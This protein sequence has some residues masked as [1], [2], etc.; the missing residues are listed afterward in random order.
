MPITHAEYAAPPAD[1]GRPAEGTETVVAGPPGGRERPRRAGSRD[2]QLRTALLA[3]L[4]LLAGLVVMKGG[5]EKQ[6]PARSWDLVAA[7]VG[8]A[9][10]S[11]PG[12]TKVAGGY[13]RGTGLVFYAE[14]GG[15]SRAQLNSWLSDLLTPLAGE[16]SGWSRTDAVIFQLQVD[17]QP[18]FKEVVRTVPSSFSQTGNW[19]VLSQLPVDLG[20][21][22]SG[23]G[24]TTTTA[25]AAAPSASPSAAPSPAASPSA[26]ASTSPTPSSSASPSATASTAATTTA[27]GALGSSTAWNPMTGTWKVSGDTYQQQDDSGYD[28]I[29]QYLKDS[30]ASYTVQVQMASLGKTLAA[31]IMLGQPKRGTRNGAVLIDVSAGNY[32]RWGLYSTA[33]GTYQFKGGSALPGTAATGEWHT[34]KIQVSPQQTTI[35][36]DGTQI[37]QTT[38]VAAGGLGLVTSVSKVEFKGWSVTS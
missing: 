23:T 22:A 14:L 18:T 29:S 37:G 35:F 17:G 4:V 24:A 36:W 25:V 34:L 7:D 28:Y 8:H 1:P 26:S 9:V 32:L 21:G 2:A 5:G 12:V 3:V 33:G 13:V 15:V 31:G 38:P 30:P 19:I 16:F 6:A 27:A 20:S 10:D 11:A